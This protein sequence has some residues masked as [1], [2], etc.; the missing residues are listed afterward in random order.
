MASR[1]RTP[2]VHFGHRLRATAFAVLTVG[3]CCFAAGAQPP[4]GVAPADAT[5]G[6]EPTNTAPTKKPTPELKWIH[7]AN[8]GEYRGHHQGAFALTPAV[9]QQLVDNFHRSPKYE[10]GSVELDGK[11]FEAGT[12]NVIQYDYEHASEMAPWEGS[13]PASGAPAAGWVR[14]VELRDGPNGGKQLWALSWLG[15]QIR[16]QIDNNEYDSVS[17]AWNPEGVDWRTGEPIGAVLTS[18]AFTNHPFLQDLTSLAAAARRVMGWAAAGQP[19]THSVKPRAST[20]EAYAGSSTPP[21]WESRIVMPPEIQALLG[22]LCTIH[23]LQPSSDNA[24]IIKAAENAAAS[25]GDL[26]AVLAALGVSD[27]AAALKQIPEL[28]AA[29]GKLSELQSQLNG[30]MAADAS[31]DATVSD[32][33]AVAGMS[34]QGLM[35]DGRVNPLLLSTFKA[36][37]ERCISVE[38]GKLPKD[39]AGN[40]NVGDVRQARER[41]RQ[42][43]L[44]SCGVAYPVNPAT[45]H[46]ANTFAA[47]PGLGNV[48][49]QYLVPLSAH[50]LP[51]APHQLPA[52]VVATAQPGVYGTPQQ[53]LQL[54][55]PSPQPLQLPGAGYGTPA[56]VLDLSSNGP[57]QGRNLTER[58]MAYL[59]SQDPKGWET[60]NWDQKMAAARAFKAANPQLLPQQAA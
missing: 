45:A 37:R 48:S 43:F 33:D 39:K 31:A 35:R 34:A 46:L 7:V 27:P 49:T 1:W 41:G 20:A 26:N 29:A 5:A 24:T 14:D 58:V 51:G 52:G 59:A 16:R 40:L 36:E 25:G 23:K 28:V 2:G 12:R 18:I 8:E 47:G 10:L 15:P 56:P 4:P 57:Y 6:A 9:L 11:T 22:R 32:Q 13:I 30:L 44:A 17:I 60:R 55:Q 19:R 54:T 50:P 38:I 21:T 53:P 42:A 3:S